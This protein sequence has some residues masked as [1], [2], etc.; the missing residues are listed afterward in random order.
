MNKP[1]GIK[2]QTLLKQAHPDLQRLFN[3]VNEIVQCSILSSGRDLLEQQGLVTK[4][5]SKT[6]DSKHL[7]QPDGFAH[8][9]DVAPDPVDFDRKDYN[10]DL[11][12]FSGIVMG[13]AHSMNIRIRC[14][15]DWNRNNQVADEKFKDL[16]HFE[17]EQ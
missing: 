16:D 8:A 3:R 4:G 10:L 17:L 13:I 5:L 15:C 6:L 11:I 12:Y 9:V 1:F 7:I 2:S 14:G